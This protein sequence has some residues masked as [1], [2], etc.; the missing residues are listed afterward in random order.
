MVKKGYKSQSNNRIK[1]PNPG[2]TTVPAFCVF[3]R[4]ELTET[5]V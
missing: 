1:N 5:Q 3:S 4:R 2:R